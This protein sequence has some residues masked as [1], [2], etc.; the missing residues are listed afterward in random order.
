MTSPKE[1][2]PQTFLIGGLPF[3]IPLSTVPDGLRPVLVL[4]IAQPFFDQI[5]T[6]KKRAELREMKE[7]WR[8]RLEGRM[9]AAVA[10]SN[11]QNTA[12]RDPAWMLFPWEGYE[13]GNCPSSYVKGGLREGDHVYEIILNQGTR[14]ALS[15]VLQ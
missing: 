13:I 14:R 1:Y 11:R 2:S 12:F 3:P 6:G 10:I 4:H 5:R 8:S 9:Y 15:P 7:Y